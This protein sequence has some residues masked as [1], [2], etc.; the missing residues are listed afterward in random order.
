MIRLLTLLA[1]VSLTGCRP[2]A[3]SYESNTS[4]GEFESHQNSGS[5]GS[6]AAGNNSAALETVPDVRAPFEMPVAMRSEYEIYD[7][8]MIVQALREDLIADGGGLS[9]TTTPCHGS[10]Q[11]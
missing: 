5:Q 9:S 3:Y 10:V 11:L 2:D 8:G 6:A 1:L 4:G 7:Q